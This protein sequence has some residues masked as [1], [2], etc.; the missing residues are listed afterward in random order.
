MRTARQGAKALPDLPRAGSKLS[1]PMA[2]ILERCRQWRSDPTGLLVFVVA[3]LWLTHPTAAQQLWQ[4]A[5]G[6]TAESNRNGQSTR[7]P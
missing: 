4:Q 2:M 3:G 6:A 5:A 1:K 7:V